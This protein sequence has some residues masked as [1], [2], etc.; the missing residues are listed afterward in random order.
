M[1]DTVFNRRLHPVSVLVLCAA[2]GGCG[3]GSSDPGVPEP[4]NTSDVKPETID[5][6]WEN[7]IEMEALGFQNL[8]F[9]QVYANGGR[10]QYCVRWESEQ[11]VGR[12]ER[13]AIAQMIDAQVN[14]WVGGWLA[15]HDGWAY[16]R[17]DVR[18][19]AWAVRER[20]VLAD[21]DDAIETVYAGDLDAGGAPK[22]PDTCARDARGNGNTDASCPG[23]AAARFDMSL[24]GTDGFEGGAGGDWGQ[25]VSSHYILDAALSPGAESQIIEHEIGHGFNLP[26]FYEP[27]QFPPT[28]L[29][30]AIMQAG[31]SPTITPWDGW[32]LR[33]VW[34][35]LKRQQPGR[36]AR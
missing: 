36:F 10:L 17:V 1:S 34:S 28:G 12:D 22:C 23:G 21:I 7:R 25:R 24:W 14:H 29:P 4:P 9:D 11:R 33:R 27:A 35:E 8:I 31:A 26:D 16:P 3:G 18:V 15:G 19:V 20:G 13:R 2:L 32:M 30:P 6:V 5:W